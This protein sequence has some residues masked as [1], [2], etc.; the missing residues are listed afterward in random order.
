MDARGLVP[1]ALHVL[2]VA[3]GIE[4]RLRVG[5]ALPAQ[6]QH[7]IAQLA[8]EVAVVELISK[9]LRNKEIAVA[10]GIPEGTV[11][12][13][14]HRAATELRRVLGDLGPGRKRKKL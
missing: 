5:T 6:L 9:G 1:G 4:V 7:A 11:L 2:D 10:L 13:Y 8:Q 12:V 14:A 3:A